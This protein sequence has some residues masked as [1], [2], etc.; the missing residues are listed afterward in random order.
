MINKNRKTLQILFL[1]KDLDPIFFEFLTDNIEYPNKKLTF[2]N[3]TSLKSSSINIILLFFFCNI[4]STKLQNKTAGNKIKESL[5]Y[6]ISKKKGKVIP[7]NLKQQLQK[8]FRFSNCQT[9]DNKMSLAKFLTS[10]STVQEF[11]LI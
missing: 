7:N 4:F 10:T 8:N 1:I 5:L 6:D 11:N 9:K 3:D 2:T